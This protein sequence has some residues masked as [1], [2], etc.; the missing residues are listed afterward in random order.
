MEPSTSLVSVEWLRVHE[1]EPDVVVLDASVGGPGPVRIRGAGRFDLDGALSDHRSG[2]PHMMPSPGDFER[3]MGR[4]GVHGRSRIVLY[5]SRGVYSSPRAWWMLRAM[6]HRRVSVLDGGLPAWIEAGFQVEPNAPGHRGGGTFKAQPETGWFCGFPEVVEALSDPRCV[7]VDVRSEGRFQGVEPE[8][9]PGL[10][11]GHMPGSRNIPF[12]RFLASGRYLSPAVLRGILIPMVPEDSRLVFSCG[13]GVTACIGALAA[14]HAGCR[15]VS[16]YD[17][18]W[19]E[20]GA[21]SDLPVS[22]GSA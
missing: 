1:A 14:V 17:G 6:G 16:V 5:D 11:P 3:E 4:L 15:D 12:T 9:R 19:S 20:W 21:P 8:P 18:S 13:S 2:L 7:V 10:R 22:T